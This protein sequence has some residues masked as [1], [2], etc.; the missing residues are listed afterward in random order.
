MAAGCSL[1]SVGFYELAGTQSGAD[2]PRIKEDGLIASEPNF[3]FGGVRQGAKL[4][5]TFHVINRS[6]VPVV[7]AGVRVSCD[8]TAAALSE[9]ELAPGENATV[10][11]EWDTTGRRGECRTEAF[12]CYS[13]PFVTEENT[14]SPFVLPLSLRAIVEPDVLCT[15]ESL[16]F[17]ERAGETFEVTSRTRDRSP[18]P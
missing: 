7:L 5:H 15:P 13:R 1:I 10:S 8:C 4:K 9:R 18:S 14:D 12:V 11:L 16:D 3:N 2:H 6:D 17:D